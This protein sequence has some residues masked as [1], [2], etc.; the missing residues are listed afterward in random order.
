MVFYRA[1][2]SGSR[3]QDSK[4]HSD[5]YCTGLDGTGLPVCVYGAVHSSSVTVS[6][7]LWMCMDGNRMAVGM[8]ASQTSHTQ[9]IGLHQYIYV[10]V[11]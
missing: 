8:L 10:L 2:Q 5:R 3:L 1:F 11:I 7:P 6:L 4:A 9:P